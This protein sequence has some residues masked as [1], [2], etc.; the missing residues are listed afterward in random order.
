M[1]M[2]RIGV[3]A[4]TFVL[5]AGLLLFPMDSYISQP[6]GAYD[7]SPLVEV[8]HQAE[9]DTG[10]FSLMTI[11]L[12]KATPLTYALSRFSD[13]RKLLPSTSVRRQGENEAEYNLRQQRLMANSQYNAITVAFQQANL[14]VDIELKGVI[15]M[16]VLKQGASSTLL[17][18][19]DIIH[20]IDGMAIK[21]SGDFAALIAD[22]EKGDKIQ[23]V[24]ERDGE[25]EE[26]MISLKPIPG[27][28]DR[29]GL[30]IQFEEDR[31]VT[32]DPKVTMHTSNIGGPSA[33]LMFTLEILNRLKAED[34]TK[35]YQIAGT[36]EMLEDG[37]VGRIGGID[38]KVM[39]AA[40]SG[41]DIFF[42]PDDDIP[43][44]VKAKNRDVQTN[45]EEAI[46]TAEK[47]GTEMMIVPV[48][49][50]EDALNYL[51]QLDDMSALR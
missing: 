47:I 46:E 41:I 49:T 29:V 45:Y 39:A 36:G 44:E 20:E 1:R 27:S 48:K 37:T 31:D 51:A 2:K 5:L 16:Q 11:S 14:P 10:T 42:A 23:L 9:E 17:K 3:I 28:E 21:N 12:A 7:L 24:I 19:G 33:G 4:V 32:T 15:V 43:E 26:V 6:G 25:K 38:F 40:K 30:G 22:K 34:L 13:E 18:T 50:I 35:G 8:D